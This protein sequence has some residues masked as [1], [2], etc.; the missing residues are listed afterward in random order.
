MAALLK[1]IT[2]CG[3]KLGVRI[4]FA[5][6]SKFAVFMA[7]ISCHITSLVY[8]SWIRNK[9]IIVLWMKHDKSVA[10]V[11]AHLVACDDIALLA[12]SMYHI[13]IVI[14]HTI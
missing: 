13:A 8:W 1:T 2:I 11:H 3:G 5:Q 7:M 10:W 9:A 14:E 6:F 12:L 4:L